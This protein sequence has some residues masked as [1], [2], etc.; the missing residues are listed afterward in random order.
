MEEISVK[1]DTEPL[2]EAER[3]GTYFTRVIS[4]LGITLNSDTQKLSKKQLTPL[5]F[6]NV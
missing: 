3:A 5:R 2:S 1:H 6:R 4:A